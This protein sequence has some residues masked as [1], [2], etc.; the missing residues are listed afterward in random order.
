M[1]SRGLVVQPLVDIKASSTRLNQVVVD[2]SFLETGFIWASET[3]RARGGTRTFA[4]VRYR[5]ADNSLGERTVI[6]AG[7]AL[8]AAGDA[9]FAIDASQ[10]YVAVPGSADRYHP[11][12]GMVLRFNSDGSSPEDSIS[13]SAVLAAG[14]TLPSAI[15]TEPSSNRVWVS[16]VD[17]EESRQSL[18]AAKAGSYTALAVVP[19]D[20]HNDLLKVRSDGVLERASAAHDS[21]LLSFDASAWGYPIAV[22]AGADGQIFLSLYSPSVFRPVTVVTLLPPR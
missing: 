19:H 9:V 16:G 17:P 20:D 2:P 15:A 7:I 1:T 22:A 12:W 13:E 3:R 10:I 14:Y 21:V 18:N 6:V 5:L 4:V 8:P 11:H